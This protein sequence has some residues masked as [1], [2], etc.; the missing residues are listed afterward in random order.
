M[1]GTGLDLRLARANGT[2]VGCEWLVA[3]SHPPDSARRVRPGTD[4]DRC[5]SEAA[6]ARLNNRPASPPPTTVPSSR[7]KKPR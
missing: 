5:Y 6:G 7:V 3:G 1:I 4:R 2:S